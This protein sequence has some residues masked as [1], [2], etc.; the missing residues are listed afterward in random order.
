MQTKS[1][2]VIALAFLLATSSSRFSGQTP[3]HAT[4]GSCFFHLFFVAFLIILAA[5]IA[6]ASV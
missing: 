6:S 3:T 2:P 1:K 4:S 5:V